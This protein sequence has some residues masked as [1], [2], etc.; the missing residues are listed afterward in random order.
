MSPPLWNS[1][2]HLS[3][4]RG[5]GRTLICYD[6]LTETQGTGRVE[7]AMEGLRSPL[8]VPA[9]HPGSL[10]PPRYTKGLPGEPVSALALSLCIFAP[11]RLVSAGSPT[12]GCGS[13]SQTRRGA[14]EGQCQGSTALGAGQGESTGQGGQELCVESKP[15]CLPAS[16]FMPVRWE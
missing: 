14:G 13:C 11:G 6:S 5:W 16:V 9:G 10:R 12:R 3:Q 2:S 8:F 15:P 4:G 7:E 1:V